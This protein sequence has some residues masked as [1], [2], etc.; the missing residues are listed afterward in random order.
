ME[1][2]KDKIDTETPLSSIKSTNLSPIDS[3]NNPKK[4]T[5]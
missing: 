3:E 2:E 5:I 4:K 1:K